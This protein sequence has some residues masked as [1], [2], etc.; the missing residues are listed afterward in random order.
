[1]VLFSFRWRLLV[2]RKW[3]ILRL[4]YGG[5]MHKNWLTLSFYCFV[6]IILLFSLYLDQMTILSICIHHI[7]FCLL[8]YL[9]WVT[10]CFL[11]GEILAETIEMWSERVRFAPILS[12]SRRRTFLISFLFKV[13]YLLNWTITFVVQMNCEELQQNASREAKT[14]KDSLFVLISQLSSRVQRMKVSIRCRLFL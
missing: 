4:K 2:I 14:I 12:T 11:Q 6:E 13:G 9:I 5:S 3:V 10:P 8:L 1:M 7:C